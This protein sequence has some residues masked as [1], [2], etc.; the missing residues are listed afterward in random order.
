[1]VVVVVVVVVVVG[2]ERS[3]T[4][5]RAWHVG[6]HPE[7]AWRGHERWKKKDIHG[8]GRVCRNTKYSL[9]VIGKIGPPSAGTA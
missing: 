1:M 2:F 6:E 9:I 8:R 4:V 7:C 5:E 3:W